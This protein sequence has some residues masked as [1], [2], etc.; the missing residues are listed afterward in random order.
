M[1]EYKK[2]IADSI[3]EEKLMGKGAVLI[4][5]PKWC[6]KTA[7]AEQIAKSSLYMADPRITKQN[8]M[9]A[10]TNPE[11]LLRGDT[12]RLIDEWQLAPKL[13]DAARFEV[14]HQKEFGQF[15]GSSA[16]TD[17]S[18][19]NHSGTGR[20]SWLKMRTMSLFESGESNGSVSIKQLC[21][22]KEI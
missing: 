8:L 11:Y 21:L 4:E 13:W 5:G 16:P 1:F 20:F 6:G 15:I 9:L 14:D 12:P 18:N 22:N 2:R 3:L 17:L 19:V 10:D 7:T